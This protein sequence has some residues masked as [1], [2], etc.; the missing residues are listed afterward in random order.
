M[1]L[2]TDP[3]WIERIKSIK[4]NNLSWGAGRIL[5][6][7]QQ[8]AARSGVEY[9][10]PSEPTIRRKLRTEW[11]PLDKERKTQYLYFYWPESMMNGSLPWE[12]SAAGLEL[13]R[14]YPIERPYVRQV[15][16]FWRVT[17]AMPK[18]DGAPPEKY[19]ALRNLI[20][21]ILTLRDHADLLPDLTPSKRVASTAELQHL[22]PPM[23]ARSIE[24]AIAFGVYTAE[25]QQMQELLSPFRPDFIH[26][27]REAFEEG[28]ARRTITAEGDNDEQE[29]E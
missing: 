2:E 22:P 7:M 12:A 18:H 27:V 16:W 1:P 8:E 11:D 5:K 20:A 6:E 4:A 3:Y 26:K 29:R 15:K 21:L 25:L 19:F 14:H 13:L 24:D 23:M 28:K 17:Q 10:G 9:Q